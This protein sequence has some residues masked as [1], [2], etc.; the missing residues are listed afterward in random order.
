MVAHTVIPA[1]RRLRQKDL[2]FM[3][4]LG[5]MVRLCLKRKVGTD[6]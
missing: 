2:R 5:Y 6:A 4:S 1:L 3:V